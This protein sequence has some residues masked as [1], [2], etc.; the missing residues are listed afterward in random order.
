MPSSPVLRLTEA[1]TEPLVIRHDAD[2]VCTL[3]LNRPAKLNALTPPLFVELRA[4][5]DALATDESVGCVVLTGAGR[6]FCAG[7]DLGGIAAGDRPPTPHFQAETIDSLE[8][9]PQ[10]TMAKVRGHCFTGGLELALGCDLIVSTRSAQFGDTHG[11]WGLVAAWGMTVRLPERVGLAKAK[12]LM[13]TARRITGQEGEGIGLVNRAVADDELDAAA[14]EM[15]GAIVANSWDTSRF[16]KAILADA[17]EMT[18][19]EALAYERSSPYGRPRD[20]AE[21]LAA[22]GR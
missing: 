2:G 12:E 19:E 17:R 14:A 11:Q 18:R 1:M 20:M 7:N 8:A 3:T 10:P 22:G 16:D 15:A 13:Y 4:H 21:R 5:I 6:S 9:L